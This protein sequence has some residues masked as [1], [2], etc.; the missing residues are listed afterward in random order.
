MSH[1][2]LTHVEKLLFNNKNDDEEDKDV[3][4]DSLLMSSEQN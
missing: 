1:Q 3:K 2:H 4:D